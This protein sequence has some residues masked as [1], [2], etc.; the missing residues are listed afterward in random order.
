[1]KR[2][3][4]YSISLRGFFLLVIALSLSLQSFGQEYASVAVENASAFQR[5]SRPEKFLS[6]DG[7]VSLKEALELIKD[8]FQVKFA[9]KEGLLDGKRVSQSLLHNEAYTLEVLLEK[10]L[11]NSRLEYKRI[12]KKQFSIFLNRKES[13]NTPAQK[14]SESMLAL[15]PAMNTLDESAGY[16]IQVS[17]TVTAQED[18]QPLPGVNV[19]VKG[20]ANGT[21]TDSDGKYSINLPE[22][23]G[24]LIFS[25]IGYGI[26]EVP[27]SNQTV[28]DI[29]LVQEAQ[30]L[31]EVVV[32]ALGIEKS[33]AAIAYSLTEVNG[34]EFT[35][36]RE[37]NIAN[38][39]TGMVAGVN[40]TGLSTGP[41]GS[42]RVVIRGN[43]SLTGNSQPL[44]VINGMPINN[45]VPG[46]SND[47]NSFGL[48]GVDRGDG[49]GAMNPDDI[50]SI[51][52]LKG[53]TA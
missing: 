12:N 24:T 49:I 29:V 9:Y 48:S 35:Q 39:L 31:S 15:D 22:G 23:G 14:G 53:G 43:G 1:M 51:T 44:Y 30:S 42:S 4:Y 46:G 41:G 11:A 36:A 26:Q 33:K 2:F 13:R 5:S 21:N 38:A 3:D 47:P 20:T 40:A 37:N 52:V 17:G 50:E 18:G 16:D 27:V 6:E 25:F 32:T 19:V 10:I 45:S 34:D 8:Q 7:T 28:V